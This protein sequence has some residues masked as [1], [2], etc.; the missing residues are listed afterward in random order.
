[1]NVNV[2]GAPVSF[3]VFELTPEGA[4]T[5]APDDMLR[6]LADA[7]YRGID[8]GPL[9]YLGHGDELPARLREYGLELAG[10]W[11]QLPFT[12]DDAKALSDF[13]I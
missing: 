3:G 13:G 4:E 9:G 1:M 8:L 10:G 11:V 6:V 5:M 12:D 2:A 7:G